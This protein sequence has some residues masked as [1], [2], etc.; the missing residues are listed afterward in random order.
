MHKVAAGQSPNKMANVVNENNILP[1]NLT[2]S[3]PDG[4]PDPF[5][6]IV[7]AILI[8]KVLRRSFSSLI[9]E[10]TDVEARYLKTFIEGMYEPLALLLDEWGLPPLE[11]P[12]FWR[13]EI[14][15]LLEKRLAPRR[16]NQTDNVTDFRSIKSA[17]NIMDIAAQYT[18]LTRAGNHYRGLCPLHVEKTPSFVVYPD[19]QR[20][21]CYGACAEGGDVISLT[22]RLMETGKW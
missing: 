19:S 13:S 15:P 4:M 6:A 7:G 17:V 12:G 22:Q 8:R 20:W 3:V 10:L 2:P 9:R 1:K 21:Q 16:S 5:Q 14:L 11:G 18:D